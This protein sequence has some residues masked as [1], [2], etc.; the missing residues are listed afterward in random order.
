MDRG[1]NKEWIGFR[2]FSFAGFEN[3]LDFYENQRI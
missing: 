1:W 3:L 2:V